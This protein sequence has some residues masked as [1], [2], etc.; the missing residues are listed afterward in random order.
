MIEF[1]KDGAFKFGSFMKGVTGQELPLPLTFAGKYQV[2]DSSHVK[3]SVSKGVTV[4][5]SG[6]PM[7]L[8]Y[9]ISGDTL[10][11]QGLSDITKAAKYH[12]VR[13]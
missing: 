11:L 2:V 12:R 1:S 7:T 9:S 13:Q 5:S 6:S 4:P 10:E 8:S 3:L